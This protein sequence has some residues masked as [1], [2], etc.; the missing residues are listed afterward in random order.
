MEWLAGAAGAVLEA[1]ESPGFLVAG[2][3]IVLWNLSGLEERLKEADSG[4]KELLRRIDG[5]PC[6]EPLSAGMAEQPGTSPC[7]HDLAADDEPA[8]GQARGRK[9][10]AHGA[11]H[12]A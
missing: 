8:H 2:L 5:Q 7:R 11:T 12:E 10:S 9:E 3:V 6:R 1:I 4:I